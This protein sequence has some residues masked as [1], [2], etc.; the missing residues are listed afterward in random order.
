MAVFSSTTKEGKLMKFIILFLW[1]F[2]SQAQAHEISFSHLRLELQAQGSQVQFDMPIKD[3]LRQLEGVSAAQLFNPKDLVQLEPR[4][5]KLIESRLIFV[6]AEQKLGFSGLKLEPIPA[7]QEIRASWILSG[8]SLNST[9]LIKSQIFPDNPL[10]K[11][12]LDVYKNQLLDVYKNQ[13]LDVYKNQ[14]EQQLIFDAKKTEIKITNAEQPV[15]QVLWTFFLEGIRHIYIGPD[16]ILFII[17]LLLLGGNLWQLLKI[18]SAFTLAHSLTLALATLGILNLP[19]E[20]VEPIIAASIV[21][22]GV[23]SLLSKNKTDLRVLFAFGFGLIHGFGFASVLAELELP[24]QALALA[25]LAFNFGVEF[26]QMCIVLLIA[27]LLAWLRRHS[28]QK[29][30]LVVRLASLGV[31]VM[32]AYWFIERVTA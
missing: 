23:H 14:L 6:L 30:V 24:Q 21:F 17:G 3:L 26:G 32:G 29:A 4:I 2:L 18:V 8:L 19:A 7:R 10:H 5:F 27:P 16:H 15:W 28:P 12:F 11:T 1:C 22:V 25:L 9:F 31:I 20:V 13:L